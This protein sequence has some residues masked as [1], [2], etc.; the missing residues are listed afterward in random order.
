M[1][2]IAVLGLVLIAIFT[3]AIPWLTGVLSPT[4]EPPQPSVT[5]T[6][7]P[8]STEPP[9][10]V[11]ISLQEN[12]L[13]LSEKELQDKVD[14]LIDMANQSGEAKIEYIRVKLEQDKMLIS[15]EGEVRGY[16]GKTEDLVVRFEGRTVFASGKVSAFGLSPTLTAT[17]EIDTEAGKPSVE[18]KSFKLGVWAISRF[19]LSKDKISE[20]INDA[21]E[22]GGLKLPV[23]LESIRI[24]D[25]KIIVVY[26]QE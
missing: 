25:G 3:P 11:E 18:V 8:Q 22:S 2:L 20:I 15:A 14:K 16:K 9:Q 10:P 4:E 5:P 21:I 19:G 26:K 12:A 13:T 6:E 24:E 7:L 17:V 1:I 23:D